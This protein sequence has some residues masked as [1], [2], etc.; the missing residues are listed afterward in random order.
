MSEN[1]L[2]TTNRVSGSLKQVEPPHPLNPF[3]NRDLGGAFWTT[4]DL[5]TQEGR[6]LS[7]DAFGPTVDDM[8][9]WINKTFIARDVLVHDAQTTDEQ[10]GEVIPL[11]RVVLIGANGGMVAW[12][13]RGATRSLTRIGQ[14]WGPPPWVDGLPI[15]ITEIAVG[16]NKRTHLLTV[17][18]EAVVKQLADSK[19]ARPS[20]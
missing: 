18:Q 11:V 2:V 10:T 14:T 13:G 1:E 8:S 6:Y 7:D 9:K 12:T 5:Q 16:A 20:V 4:L 3:E 19:G 15:K 17:D